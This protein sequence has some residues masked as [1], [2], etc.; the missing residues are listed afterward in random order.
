MYVDPIY[1]Y[2]DGN[3]VSY[4]ECITYYYQI[5]PI[6]S[7]Y[8]SDSQLETL[9]KL[10]QEKILTVNMPGTIMI[11][12]KRINEGSI[13]KYYEQLY[14]VHKNGDKLDSLKQAYMNNVKRQLSEKIKYSYHIYI[15]FVDNREPLKKKAF[16]GILKKNNDPLNKRMLNLTEIVDEQIYKKLE[17][18]LTVS[19][20]SKED[21]QALHNYLAIPVEGNV[22]DYSTAPQATTLEYSYKYVNQPSFH[23]IFSRVLIAEKI[24]NDRLENG[25]KANV[26]INE[27]QLYG[28]PVDTII[29]FDLEHTQVFK[30]NMRGKREDIR[31]SARR[32]NNLSDRRDKDAEK[33]MQ[34]A[35]IGEEVDPSIEDS[36]IRWQMMFRIRA[37]TEEMLTKRSDNIQKKFE[38]KGIKLTYAIGEQEK[39][40][41]NLFPFKNT[42]YHFLKLTD[43]LY[44]SHFNFFGGLYIGEEDKGVILSYTVPAD[45]PVR[46]DV[47]APMKGLTKTSSTTSIFAGETGSGKSQLANSIILLSMIFYGHKTLNIDPKGDRYKLVE[48]LNQ[49]GDITSHLIIGDKNS[50]S[51]MFDAFLLNPEDQVHALSVAKND[52]VSL[53]RA[54]NP[55]QRVDLLKIDEA[56]EKMCL[57]KAN[58]SIK[59]LAMTHLVNYLMEFDP[60]TAS[61]VK[62]LK[63]DPM[64]RLFYGD[65][66]TDISQ[67]FNLEKPYNLVTFARMPVYSSNSDKQKGYAYDDNNLEHKIFALVLSK[68]NDITNMFIRLN[69]GIAKTVS[70]DEAKLYATVPGGMSI[71]V[72]NNLIARS[73][74]CNMGIILQNWSDIPDSIINNTGQFFIGNMGSKAEIELILKHFDLENNSALYST[75]QDRTKNE[76]VSDSKKYNFLYCDYNNRKCITRMKILDIFQKAFRTFK[77]EDIRVEKDEIMNGDDPYE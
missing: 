54:V 68:V 45:L 6:N 66:Q 42:F 59:Q 44:F 16:S 37:N 62:S 4:N 75:L 11:T 51:G 28:Y 24:E 30:N 53:V 29:K 48:M 64:A 8:A 41:N 57:A 25:Y 33:A 1:I 15:A 9:I 21:T 65:D 50:M 76:G 46:I 67:A 23:A 14:K 5:K 2:G 3:I 71:L 26:A 10:L 74:L 49:F 36:K 19:R 38:G 39:L 56:Y 52:I 34:L 60:G 77:N 32:Y 13:L 17:S 43:V 12:P 69:K 7:L 40:A 18:S 63:N 72:N 22:Y 55:D 35:K 27:I 47:E 61:N 73:E 70:F 20:L 58:G 31:K